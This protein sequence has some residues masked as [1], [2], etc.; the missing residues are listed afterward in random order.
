MTSN[1]IL[2][3]TDVAQSGLSLPPGRMGLPAYDREHA[4]DADPASGAPS[5]EDAFSAARLND[6]EHLLAKRIRRARATPTQSVPAPYQRSLSFIPFRS[7]VYS[8][9]GL[10]DIRHS[11]LLAR[12]SVTEN[13]SDETMAGAV[14]AMMEIAE[15]KGWKKCHLTG[16]ERFKRLVA[17]AAARQGLRISGVSRDIAAVWRTEADRVAAGLSSVDTNTLRRE[18][19]PEPAVTVAPVVAPPVA[20][21]SVP[22][23][24]PEPIATETPEALKASVAHAL[25][26]AT[27]PP[28]RRALFGRPSAEAGFSAGDPDEDYD[29]PHAAA[30]PAR[31]AASMPAPAG[32]GVA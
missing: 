2:H 24:A 17:V 13:C 10:P 4:E 7:D 26:A 11:R 27:Q 25:T 8:A 14:A 28:P 29:L 20:A 3:I 21:P 23:A 16:S 12:M 22:Q 1:A 32:A 31:A 15:I 6:S 9:P 30:L 18:Q 19:D 5:P